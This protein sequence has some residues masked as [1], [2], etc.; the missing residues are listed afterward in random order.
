M[1]K[2]FLENYNHRVTRSFVRIGTVKRNQNQNPERS[3]DQAR[4]SE[5]GSRA[6]VMDFLS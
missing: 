3:V 4:E 6:F 5:H 2:T 1:E